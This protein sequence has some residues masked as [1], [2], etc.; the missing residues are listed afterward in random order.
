MVRAVPLAPSG[1]QS[2]GYLRGTCEMALSIDICAAFFG[3]LS[4]AQ[5]VAPEL[6]L[7]KW[8]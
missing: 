4:Q 2:R 5:S 1:H 6:L 8:P 7:K 3:G